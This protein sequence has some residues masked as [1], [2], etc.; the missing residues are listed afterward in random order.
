[1]LPVAVGLV[2][3]TV[4]LRY[5]YAIDVLAGFVWFVAV[6]RWWSW[7]KGGGGATGFPLILRIQDSTII[8]VFTGKTELTGA[9]Q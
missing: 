2:L 8:P 4:Y 3:S 1:M 6:R 9:V 5:H 7:A